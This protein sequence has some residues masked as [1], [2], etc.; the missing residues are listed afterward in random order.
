MAT[1]IDSQKCNK[2]CLGHSSYPTS[3]CIQPIKRESSLEMEF[4]EHLFRDTSL[5][6]RFKVEI[7]ILI[8]R[9]R[10]AIQFLHFGQGK[11]IHQ[12]VWFLSPCFKSTHYCR[13]SIWIFIEEEVVWVVD[14]DCVGQV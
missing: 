3:F 6:A 14:K 11:S 1:C 10:W 9:A 13:Q 2:V 12:A 7:R 5:Q 4:K 8:A